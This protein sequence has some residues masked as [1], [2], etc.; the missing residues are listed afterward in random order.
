[1]A[2]LKRLGRAPLAVASVCGVFSLK[3]TGCGP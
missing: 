3:A 1:M 2:D